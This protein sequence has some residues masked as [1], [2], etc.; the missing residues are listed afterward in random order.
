MNHD[1]APRSGDGKVVIKNGFKGAE[2]PIASFIASFRVFFTKNV[3]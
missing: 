1:C 3:S 2:P